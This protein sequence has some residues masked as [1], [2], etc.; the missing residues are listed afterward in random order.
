VLSPAQPQY[1]YSLSYNDLKSFLQLVWQYTSIDA[2][3]F[4]IVWMH[5][6]KGIK[7]RFYC[8]DS[9]LNGGDNRIIFVENYWKLHS[10][11]VEDVEKLMMKYKGWHFYYQVLPLSKIPQ[12]GRGSAK[13]IL[14]GKILWADID[15]KQQVDGDPPFYGC[16]E[17]EDYRLECYYREGDKV[18]KVDRP[19]LKQL[20]NKLNELGIPPTLI[21]DSG[22]GYHLYWTLLEEV[23]AKQLKQLE[24]KLVDYL[25]KNGINVDLQTR[26]LARIL[27]L[28]YTINPRTNRLVNIIMWGNAEYTAKEIEEKIM[29]KTTDFN[30]KND[31]EDIEVKVEQP[32]S[33][34]QKI[35]IN[36]LRKLDDSQILKIKELLKQAYKPGHRQNI[37]AYLAGWMIKAKIHPISVLKI[38]K[39]LHDETNDEE[40]IEVRAAA[41]TYTYSK[42]GID[43]TPCT[44]E[45]KKLLGSDK[46]W[47][48]KTSDI[49]EVKG[50]PSLLGELESV[51]QDEGRAL[52]IMFE[53]EEILNTISP[54]KDSI[55]EVMDYEKQLYAVA[56]L[57]KLIVVRAK[58]ADNKLVYKEKVLEGAPTRL[59]VYINPLKTQNTKY[60][61]VWETVVRPYPIVLG[62]AYLQDIIDNLSIE[63]LVV[64]R[65][66]VND[67]LSA[68]FNAFIKRNRAEVK[69]ELD[70]EGFYYIDGKIV[71]VGDN[72]YKPTNV[73]ELKEALLLVNELVDNW[74][75]HVK[76]R[77]ITILKWGI[78]SPFIYVYKAKYG[79][80]IPYLYLYGASYTGKTSQA[81]IILYIWSKTTNMKSGST[82]D[83]IPRLGSVLSQSTYPVVINEPG[84]LIVN[85]ELIDVLKAAIELKVA[86]GKF[87]RGVFRIYRHWHH[88]YLQA[89]DHYH[90]TTPY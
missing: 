47:G 84:P 46:L 60:K 8:I 36:L 48:I 89:T 77:F 63:G 56:N 76:D 20:L 28:P 24:D 72:I 41:V 39:L 23:D 44:E 18:I 5:N 54:F 52:D 61:V 71:Y 11:V 50:K 68:L 29:R 25:K 58:R 15:Y 85:E 32:E 62:P 70:S 31:E 13:E 43:L 38:V 66:L 2:R 35:D 67:V 7:F 27:R 22:G 53:L 14:V 64:N 51:L 55:I 42:R 26:D 57:R 34:N 37:L 6:E 75:S 81:E 65:R 49:E 17:Y 59:E 33:N 80:W 10:R 9:N 82:V 83:T 40:P 1:Y 4:S 78:I 86:R 30:T 88:L 3:C 16:R 90:E 74:F 12:S 73:N 79:K 87:I 45:I 19:P 69:S 21:I